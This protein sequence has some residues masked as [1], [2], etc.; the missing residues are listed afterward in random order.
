VREKERE[1]LCRGPSRANLLHFIELGFDMLT[2]QH[3]SRVQV[4]KQAQEA[5]AT[6][7]DSKPF[8]T[9]LSADQ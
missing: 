9:N 1:K 6:V 4:L 7:N 5:A 3:N 2:F 8:R